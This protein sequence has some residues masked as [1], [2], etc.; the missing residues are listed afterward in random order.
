MSDKLF[1]PFT[2]IPSGK[3]MRNRIALAPLTNL[4][5]H[6]DGTLS[7]EEYNWLLRRAK[8]NFGMVI[9]CAANVSKDGQGWKGELGIYDD[10]QLPGLKR[11]A[12]VIK[13]YGSLALVQIFHGG[14][15]SP[16]QLIGTQPWSASAHLMPHAKTPVP[17][18]E[19]TAED[20][21]RV[22]NDFVAAARRAEQAGFDGIELHGAHGYLLHQFL[23]TAT[24]KRTDEWGGN[25][26]NRSRLLLTVVKEIRKVVAL[27]FI[28]GVRLS[29]EDK[30]TFE[31]IDFDESLALAKI[32]AE[33]C[34]SY[35]HLSPWD[36]LKKPEKYKDGEKSLIEYFREAVP[37]TPLVV[38]GGIW[39]RADAERAIE[40]GVDFVALGKAAIA[41]ANWPTLAKSNIEASRE[42][43]TVEHLLQQDLS[44][45]FVEYMKRWKG[46]VVL[47]DTAKQN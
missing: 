40:L 22:I 5:S 34:I 4:Q 27:D 38:A 6:E 7:D 33:K 23:S 2:F 41:H 25:F 45:A 13:Q 17:V 24:N 32:L 42:P 35:I 12:A 29:P 9:T 15:R 10:Y 16:E 1:T 28:V 31:G 18:R 8:E 44:P 43:F 19:A 36:A 46:F 47:P 11:L 37:E 30:Y 3:L 14:A 21:A 26:E 20:I 39:T